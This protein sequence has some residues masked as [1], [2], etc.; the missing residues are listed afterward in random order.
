MAKGTEPSFGRLVFGKALSDTGQFLKYTKRDAMLGVFSLALGG[1]LAYVFVGKADTLKE[2]AFIAAFTFAPAG[3]VMIAVFIWHLWL[4]PS[5]LAYEA[6]KAS[7]GNS[8]PDSV[9]PKKE[10][11]NWAPWKQRSQ[12]S[13]YE[14]AK[15]L[16][17]TD[18]AAQRLSTEGS[19]FLRLL[20]EE[21]QNRKLAALPTFRPDI[22]GEQHL[23][24]PDY[25]TEVQRVAAITWAESKNFDVTHIK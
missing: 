18:P 4:A 3:I 20:L 11:V 6:A 17:K 21:V 8:K 14:F 16:A 25:E 9:V 13:L 10:Q 19:S 24:N 1:T 2:F 23:S 22:W 7:V 5:A 15:I 12:Y